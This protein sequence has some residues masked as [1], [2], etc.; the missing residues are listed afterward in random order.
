MAEAK[1]LDKVF[2]ELRTRHYSK[3]TE[4]AYL[5][6][7]KAFISFHRMKHPN[8]MGATEISQYINYLAVTRN[9]SSSTQNQALCAVIFLYKHVLKIEINE[10]DI[11]WAKKP[12][13]LPVV[14]T[15]EEVKQT[16]K[17]LKEQHG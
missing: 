12:K 3:R 4:E 13:K 17:D 6:W 5:N 7:V 16:L 9:V 14:L 1:I 10:F 15:K 11:V 2:I 8:K